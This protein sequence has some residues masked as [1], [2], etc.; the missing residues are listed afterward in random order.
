VPQI[1]TRLFFSKFVAPSVDEGF[2]AVYKIPFT[3]AFDDPLME[4]LWRFFYD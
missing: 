3:P 2:D 1:A 4:R